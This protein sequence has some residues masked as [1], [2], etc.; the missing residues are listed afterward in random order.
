[1]GKK[2]KAP[3]WWTQTVA[4]RKGWRLFRALLDRRQ[5]YE[6][7]LYH[8]CFV[9][10]SDGSPFWLFAAYG[11]NMLDLQANVAYG[12]EWFPLDGL[13][14]IG[15]LWAAQKL[16]VETNAPGYRAL[17]CTEDGMDVLTPG[18]HGMSRRGWACLPD[19]DDGDGWS[20]KSYARRV[21]L[22]NKVR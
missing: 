13:P 7:D 9:G 15:D 22:S 12:V 14:P 16:F 5:R 19:D 3:I 21:F 17:G 20:V 11:N 10:G 4:D 1:M 6:W 18:T 2:S 8:G